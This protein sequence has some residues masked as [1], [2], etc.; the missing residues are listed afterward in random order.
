MEP[1]T[2]A[3]IAA[4]LAP[5]L[6]KG[7]EKVAEK[8][9][10]ILLDSRKDLADRFTRLFTTEIISLNLSESARADDIPKQLEAK[11]G[12][13]EQLTQKVAS[14]QDL[15]KELIEAFKQMPQTE[16]AGITIN[17]KNVGQVI[18]NPTGPITQSNTFS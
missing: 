6:Q 14:N 18:N 15:L 17:A 2:L 12:L 9:V 3:A 1:F 7:G 11:P 10:E 16:F 5:Y 13:R 4:F 8:T